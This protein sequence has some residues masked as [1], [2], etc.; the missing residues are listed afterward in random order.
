[1][2]IRA[3]ISTIELKELLRPKLKLFLSVDVVGSSDFKQRS[4]TSHAHRWLNL[5]VSFY[6]SFPDILDTSVAEQ[7]QNGAL[8]GLR[9]WK[10][11]GDELIFTAELTKRDQAGLYLKAFRLALQ[12]ASEN[13]HTDDRYPER[14][15]LWLK[16][17]AWLAGFPV[18]NSEMPLETKVD[19]HSDG[20][21]YIGPM[22]DTG[23][24]LKNFATP[25]KLVLSADLAYLLVSAG[26][27]SLH[28]F[29]DG[30]EPLKG[31]MRGKPYPI[32]W[33]DCDGHDRSH[34]SRASSEMNRLKDTLLGRD[35]VKDNNLKSFLSL[36]IDST[37]GRIKRPFIMDDPFEDLRPPRD[38]EDSLAAVK[39]DLHTVLSV[40][41]DLESGAETGESTMP[42]DI[43]A[44]LGEK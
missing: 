30:D 38:Y 15:E 31:I 21:D 32:I 20:S 26:T 36:W 16:G 42:A 29:F 37:K 33:M 22:I 41:D 17:T 8:P 40:R 18:T 43:Q 2:R 24:R 6:G 44:F 7:S 1:M 34:E 9:L 28:L 19:S 39:A 14:Q 5:F 12:K 25:R 23:F 11:L 27:S 13:W 35:S 3:E 4:D 10:S